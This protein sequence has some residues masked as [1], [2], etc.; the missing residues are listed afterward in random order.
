MAEFA[1]VALLTA[2]QPL[3][4][5]LNYGISDLIELC[6][7]AA[8]IR[9]VVDD[10]AIPVCPTDRDPL[11]G[12]AAF[13]RRHRPQLVGISAYT[14]GASAALEYA[15]LAKQYGAYVVVGGYHASAVP[16]EM[17]ASPNIDAVV[18]GEGERTLRELVLHGPSAA[19]LGLT[20]KDGVTI[21]HN[22]ERPLIDDLDALPL[23]LRQIRPRRFGLDSLDY[24]VDSIYT[25][26]GCRGKC[27]FCANHLVGK[28]WRKRSNRHVLGELQ[29][30]TPPGRGK[31]KLIKLWDAS[32][33]TDT[34]RT[35]ELCDLII[36]SGLHRHFRFI[37]E[38]RVEDIIRARE[39]LTRMKEAG[40]VK[41]GAG[42]ESP[43]RATL[44]QVR[45]GLLPEAV[46]TASK[47]VSDSGLFFS[48]FFI[49][50]HE[51]EGVDDILD[52]ADFA[53]A[54]GL[55]RQNAYFFV[56]T[57]YPGTEIRTSYQRKGLIKSNDWDL[58]T[59]Y[60]AVIERAGISQTT[61]QSLVGAL[62][63]QYSL[64]KRF[65]RGERFR[66]LAA[67]LLGLVLASAK[68][69]QAHQTFSRDQ[70]EDGVWQVLRF[71]REVPERAAGPQRRRR[72]FRTLTL[73]FFHRDQAPLAISFT[74]DNRVERLVISESSQQESGVGGRRLTVNL[75]VQHLFRLAESIDP[76][77]T[78]HDVIVLL[79]KPS[80]L[81]LR[82]ALSL[83]GQAARV[84][85]V[86]LG[87]LLFD[88]RK[89]IA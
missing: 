15:A 36:D 12:C 25:S 13:L 43:N 39:I 27:T 34:A 45:K 54:E 19:V 20:F 70:P 14:C 73:R 78:G 86:L 21:V 22:P 56:M 33:M 76:R 37:A 3:P 26:R 64:S 5:F 65:A 50:G 6:S 89:R 79:L 74:D 53:V 17:L 51:N 48:K 88:L 32:F 75:S 9:D 82:W 83:L 60:N 31:R 87:M 85:P 28:R 80:A 42:I 71:L 61:L 46:H 81:Q 49:I 7:L 52:Y 8:S 66:K 77:V 84:A 47:L 44:R 2:H 72:L 18:R 38:A 55:R 57:P 4:A 24:H 62:P 30:I 29:S 59:N 67:K 10:V 63:L 69:F 11:A 41:L 58:Y 16:E 35:A 40:F 1:Q 68:V 23:P